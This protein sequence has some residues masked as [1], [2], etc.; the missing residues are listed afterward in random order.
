MKTIR[1]DTFLPAL[2]PARLRRSHLCQSRPCAIG[3][4]APSR[5][6]RRI[7]RLAPGRARNLA[8]DRSDGY[9][10]APL[11]SEPTASRSQVVPRPDG[12]APK[13]ADGFSAEVFASGLR[14]PRVIRLAPNGDIFVTE[15]VGGRV[16]IFRLEDGRIT[17]VASHVFAAELERPYGIAFYPPGP[18]PR[19]VYIGTPTKVL[20]FPY[21]N[22][23]LK[24]SGPAETIASLPG[25]DGGHW[26]RDLVFSR[27]GKTL[28]VSVGSKTNVAE[29]HPRPTAQEVAQLEAAHGIG[30]RGRRIRARP[31]PGT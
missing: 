31:G 6:R 16:R 2:S 17:P 9:L 1:P 7:Q 26:T 20:R 10:P 23:D 11:A 22:G 27:D 15:S 30:A 5:R 8:Q 24:A 19:F 14:G 29:G 4:G 13:T 3:A 25:A 21:R 18:E 28:Y 12:A